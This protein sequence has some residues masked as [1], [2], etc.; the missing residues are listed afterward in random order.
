MDGRDKPYLQRA[1]LFLSQTRARLVFCHPGRQAGS[2]H[3]QA[4]ALVC[5]VTESSFLFAR[6]AFPFFRSNG[7]GQI[8]MQEMRNDALL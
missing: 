6:L 3:G 1:A 2:T 4:R 8:S 7:G 5:L